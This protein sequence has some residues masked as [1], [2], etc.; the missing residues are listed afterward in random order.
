MGGVLS[1]KTRTLPDIFKESQYIALAVRSPCLVSILTWILTL[2]ILYQTYNGI[3]VAV[4]CIVLGY[5][6]SYEP[7]ATFF[8]STVGILVGT[9]G[10]YALL[11]WP[12]VYIVRWR[13]TDVEAMTPSKG[14]TTGPSS[15]SIQLSNISSSK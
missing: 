7:R 2:I 1:F 12:K 6:I 15:G 3:F 4:I 11:F 9:F 14:R 8:I 10:E 5:V 13:P